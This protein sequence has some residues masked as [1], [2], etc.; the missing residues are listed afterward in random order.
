[1]EGHLVFWLWLTQIS[2]V[3]A[4]TC[5]KL[6]ESFRS[7]RTV[8]EASEEELREIPG[9]G[10]SIAT[11]I[12]KHRSLKH[13]EESLAEVLKH[14]AKL[15][16][17][18]D[19]R[20]P[21][22]V[23]ELPSAPMILYYKGTLRKE[24]GIAIIGARRCTHYAKRVTSE[25]AH[26][27]ATNNIPVISGLAKGVDGYAHTA[28][29]KSGGYTLAFLG[30]GVDVCYPKE[31]HELMEGISEHGAVLSQFP[32]GTPPRRSNFPKRNQLMSA[33]AE[34]ILVVE[35]SLQSG[36]LI[37]AKFAKELR[38]P[39]YAV[40]GNIYSKENRG[41]N[42]LILE[43]ATPYLTPEQL[44]DLYAQARK[45]EPST[46]AGSSNVP[47]AQSVSHLPQESSLIE[48]EVLETIGST[49]LSIEHLTQLV[50]MKP[51]NLSEILTIM[52]LDRKIK[53]LPGGF[54]ARS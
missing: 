11:V 38:R 2:G 25:A 6:L 30:H 45:S 21:R 29:I 8:Y 23:K 40:P 39:I 50:S 16:T 19:E 51:S 14:G 3:G 9:I 22:A 48:Q 32:L 31:H 28:C 20:Y 27:L 54:V 24:R 5:K 4:R 26:Y 46:M 43:G 44:V 17:I 37:T 34:K 36:A 42:T 47:V 13:A 7:P 12:R 41:T 15:L 52:Q 35:A 10:K 53:L 1:M 18:S 49:P 33:W